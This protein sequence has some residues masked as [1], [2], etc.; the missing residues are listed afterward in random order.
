MHNDL[1]HSPFCS[2]YIQFSFFLVIFQTNFYNAMAKKKK[3]ITT[4][5]ITLKNSTTS[6]IISSGTALFD[7]VVR[8]HSRSRPAEG[9]IAMHFL[10]HFN[11]RKNGV[12]ELWRFHRLS[13][14]QFKSNGRGTRTPWRGDSLEGGHCH[15]D[16][17]SERPDWLRT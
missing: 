3:Y 13:C 6:T 11:W 4:L 14:W 12:R 5:E 9:D 1:L 2:I 15:T 17:A 7:S 16:R 8:R 10:L